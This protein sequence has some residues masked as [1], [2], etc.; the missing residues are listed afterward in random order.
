VKDAL[1]KDNVT[2]ICF[3]D[4][5]MGF[6]PDTLHVLLRK[7]Q[8]IVGANYSMR[9]PPPQFTALALDKKD[10]V[11][12]TDEKTGL[13]PAYYI[14]F[15]FAVIE[16]KVFKALETPWFLGGYNTTVQ[17][18]TTE[19]HP[20]CK[21]A[22]EKGFPVYVDHDASKKVYHVGNHNYTWQDAA[23]VKTASIKWEQ[24]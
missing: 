2:H 17:R 5:D 22:A 21:A 20:F 8:P 12:T 18:Y 7:R 13:E 6:D 24:S 10:R 11:I 3:I 15:G 14:G 4:E 19:D 23:I 9:V 16:A 1:A